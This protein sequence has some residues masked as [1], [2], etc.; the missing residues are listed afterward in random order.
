VS[1]EWEPD[2]LLL[3]VVNPLP[4]G[5]VGAGARHGLAGL[6]ERVRPVGGL[7]DHWCWAW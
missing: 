3:T 5:P 1:V 7:L 2:A 4:E 6:S